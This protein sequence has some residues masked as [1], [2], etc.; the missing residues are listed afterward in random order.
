M[1]ATVLILKVHD[2]IRLTALLCKDSTMDWTKS[3]ISSSRIF[4][5]KF[6]MR[7][8]SLDT[9]AFSSSGRACVAR[10]MLSAATVTASMKS[11]VPPPLGIFERDVKKCTF[12][13]CSACS[14]CIAS[15]SVRNEAV[16][17]GRCDKLSSS[18]THRDVEVL[19]RIALSRHFLMH[20]VLGTCIE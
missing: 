11:L 12:G 10:L 13:G 5:R 3:W 16:K 2:G 9:L 8:I 15:H 18:C 6:D 1:G 7:T 14:T 20:H 17:A 19:S 4:S